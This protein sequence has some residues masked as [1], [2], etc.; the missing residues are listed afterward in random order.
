MS[1]AG[2]TAIVTGAAQGLGRA[3]S[4][5]F[6]AD[7]ARVVLSDI[8]DDKGHAVA[9]GITTAGGEACYVHCDVSNASD[10]NA[11]MAK[12]LE[13]YG[14]VDIAVCN[15]AIVEATDFLEVTEAD[16]KRVLDINLT[17][18]FLTGQ[19][20]AKQMVAQGTGGS[21]INMSSI[22]AVVAIPAIASY[23]ACKG[24]VQQLTKA[25]ALALAPHHI[26][27]NAIGPGTIAT[28]MA[29]TVLNDSGARDKVLSR[30]PAGRLGE[31]AEIAGVARFLAGDDASYITG[32]TIYADG[33]RLGLNYTCPVPGQD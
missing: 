5:R 20:A 4:E 10:V 11:M 24:G 18:F 9:K 21:I 33:G 6:A 23:C 26:R 1:I 30:T 31:P 22:N 32:E 12:A 3:I 16:W 7:G 29:A 17:G 25:M 13:T 27:V 28:E 15:A 19:A 14:S 8:A 2:K